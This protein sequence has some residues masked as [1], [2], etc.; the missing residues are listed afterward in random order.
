MNK[1]IF[2]LAAWSKPGVSIGRRIIALGMALSF[3]MPTLSWAFEVQ[4]YGA[5]PD[6]IPAALGRVVE[7]TRG[8]NGMTLYLIQDLHC[9]NE[10]QSNIR[11][12]LGDLEDKNPGLKLVAVEG[13]T[14]IIPTR[15]L[16]AIADNPA[17]RAVMAYFMRDG[18]MTG[19][20]CAAVCDRPDFEL[21]GAENP[22]LYGRSL[23]L[24]HEF[25]TE[26]NCGLVFQLLDRIKFLQSR[27]DNAARP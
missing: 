1:S 3:L 4:S 27:Q 22:D 2:S 19:A 16:A 26:A 24:I 23:A 6:M 12:I 17:K 14:G 20:D 15:A 5:T 7:A 11:R 10:V 18:K 13:A 21:Y 25:A 9:N 8:T